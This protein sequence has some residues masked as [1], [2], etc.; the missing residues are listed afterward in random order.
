M[1]RTFGS[2]LVFIL[3]I[4]VGILIEFG[5]V[6]TKMYNNAP[7]QIIENEKVQVENKEDDVRPTDYMFS[8]SSIELIDETKLKN[9][10]K[11]ELEIAK[12][13]IFARYGYDFSSETLRDYFMKKDWYKVVSGKKVDV[14]ELNEVEQKNVSLIDNYLKKYTNQ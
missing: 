1:K 12:N 13:E 5:I 14:S 7:A 11:F 6:Y 10:S 3:G 2:I 8:K 9:L 4:G